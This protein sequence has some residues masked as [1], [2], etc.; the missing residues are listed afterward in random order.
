MKSHFKVV[1]AAAIGLTSFSLVLSFSG[2]PPDAHTG[3]PGEPAC[4]ECHLS[5][6]LNSGDGSL[7]VV[8][9]ATYAPGDT[10]DLTVQL[11]DPGQA[12]WGFELTALNSANQPAGDLVLVE[13]VRTQKS[14]AISGRQYVKH[15]AAGTEQPGPDASSQW[16]LRWAATGEVAGPVTFYAAG[17][18]A[19]YNGFNTGDYIY[20]TS[21]VVDPEP[22]ANCCQDRVG[23][24]NGQGGDEPTIGDVSVI[25]D[26]L[27]ITGSPAPLACIGE[28]DINR[29]GGATPQFEDITI[30]DVSNLIDYLFITGPS[31]GLP[32]CL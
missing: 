16:Q 5:F 3:A 28:A 21:T 11:Q 27:F 2:G 23:D 18:A 17:N 26:A 10:L 12:R 20:T 1:S 13:P 31:L 4:N 22:V 19:N 6:P 25:I 32:A 8:A 9:P 7:A 14:V 30:G 29:S 15:T 24:A